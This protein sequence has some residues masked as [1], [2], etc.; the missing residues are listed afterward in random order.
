MPPQLSAGIGAPSVLPGTIEIPAG[1]ATLGLRRETESF[2]WDNE[3][4]EYIV[5]VPAFAIDTYNV[6]NARLSRLY[7][8]GRI[9]QPG[10]LERLPIGIG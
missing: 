6:T 9:R 1:R 7:E 3:F 4:E 10:T 8:G 2:G 5:D